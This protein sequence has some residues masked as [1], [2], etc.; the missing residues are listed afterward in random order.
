MIDYQVCLNHGN[1]AFNTGDTITANEQLRTCGNDFLAKEIHHQ[2]PLIPEDLAQMCLD[3]AFKAA[4]A[5]MAQGYRIVLTH[6]GRAVLAMYPDVHVAGGNINP[7]RAAKL[8]PGTQSLTKA[9]A[10]EL[11]TKAGVTVK[12]R[13]EAE[14]ELDKLLK[15]QNVQMQRVSE[16]QEV[17]R[18]TRKTSGSQGNGGNGSGYVPDQDGLGS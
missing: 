15:S 7:K 9:N 17:A 5:L 13:C 10:G 18:I 6:Q 1:E 8:I 14:P 16:I 12:A 3:N 2:N 4:A 11:V